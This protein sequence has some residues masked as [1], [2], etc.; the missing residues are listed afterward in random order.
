[1]I[2]TFACLSLFCAVSGW[3]FAAAS[4]MYK[5][6]DNSAPELATSSV[7]LLEAFGSAIGGGVAAILFA[8]HVGSL[9]I[10]VLLGCI[11]L[12][13]AVGLSLRGTTRSTATALVL[14]VGVFTWPVA[15]KL[16]M[17]SEAKLWPGFRLLATGN[18]I[19]GRLAV[20]E[21]EGNR[22][23]SENGLL[24][25]TVPDPVAAEEAVHFALLEH[26]AP[27]S[28][29]LIGS[30]MNGAI[31]QALLHPTLERLD[32]V[33][34]DPTVLN[35]AARYFPQQWQGIR[36]DDRVRVHAIDGRLFVK[37]TRDEF[38]VILIN[39]PGPQTAQL[40]RFYTREFFH[41]A[42]A[43]LAR[44]GIL[45]LQVRAAENYI[46]PELAAFLGC[47]RRTLLEVFPE[48]TAI[49]GDTVHFFAAS[50]RGTL[51]EDVN[52]LV[53]RLRTLQVQPVYIREYYL[54][55]RMMPERMRDLENQIHSP[56]STAIN[57]DVTPVVYFYDTVLWGAQFNE[58]Y[59][60]WFRATE[61]LPF[62]GVAAI[63]GGFFVLLSTFLILRNQRV[64][65]LAVAGLSIS[66]TGL[67]LMA[68]QVLL[69]LGFQAAYGYVYQQMALLI[70]A[71]M[72][73][74]SLGAWRGRIIVS[75]HLGATVCNLRALRALQIGIAICPLVLLCVLWYCLRTTSPAGAA[76][77]ANIFFPILALLAGTLG[78]YQF[79]LASAVYFPAAEPKSLGGLYA[80]DLLGA[81]VGALVI[82]TYLVPVFG[83][84]RTAVLLAS[85][86]VFPVLLAGIALRRPASASLP[87]A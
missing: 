62:A 26:P 53:S 44:G 19:Y 49:P 4:R 58:R 18:S 59:R 63:A 38:D 43:R 16:E 40:N 75:R 31:E 35:L 79:P 77:G 13:S 37:R 15:N 55:F 3:L 86:N 71:F 39:L 64:K 46:S 69:L 83:F 32:Y 82:S 85:M 61:R 9:Q 12:L 28:V 24:S 76:I 41:E 25:F 68:V 80:L 78:G 20:V 33:E 60:N 23:L 81:A 47:I 66:I 87:V 42:A 21:S 65:P 22:S 45:S 52:V 34:L 36:G 57:R 27:K 17:W 30:G 48:V 73:G 1:V 67:T 10:A 29:L 14:L 6:H 74:M 56:S 5:T 2:G 70:A 84:V 54:P 72:A 7:Y 50:D 51:T 8:M 11:N